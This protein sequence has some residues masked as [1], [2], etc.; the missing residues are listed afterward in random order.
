MNHLDDEHFSG[1]ELAE[2][3]FLSREQTHRKIKQSTSL[4]TGKFIRYIKILKAYAY[5][6]EGNFSVSE[7]S[8]KVGF[9]DPSYFNKCF[10][11]ETGSSPGEVKK[12]GDVALLNKTPLFPFYEIPEIKE[13]LEK[14]GVIF[15]FPHSDKEDHAIPKALSEKQKGKTVKT[16]LIAGTASFVLLISLFFWAG[17]KNGKSK[18]DLKGNNRIVVLPFTNRTGDSSLNSI[19]DIAS[20]WLSNQLAELKIIQT[21]PYFTIKQYQ[22]YIGILPDDPQG[23]PTFQD[24][25]AARYFING[26]YYLKDSQVFFDA[27]FVD[28]GSLQ[29]IYSLPPIHGPLDSVMNMIEDIRLKFAGLI[30]NLEE[31][32]LGKRNPPNYEAYT[33]FL[34]GLHEMTVGLSTNE[35]QLYLEK[36]ATLEPNFVMP[37]VYLGWYYRGKKFDSLLQQIAA[38][39]TITK[40]E[41]DV[42]DFMYHLWN[43][44][45]KESFQLVF[46]DI[47]KYPGDYFFNLFA[48]YNA[49]S[50]FFPRLALK[51]LDQIKDPLP[52]NE[53]GIWHYY[54]VWNYSE[55]LLMLGQYQDA[56]NYLQ[57]IPLEHYNLAIPHLLISALV[58]LGKPGTEV[59][60]LIEKIAKEKMKYLTGKF[61]LN[62]QKIFAEYYTVAAYYFY[63][64]G[65]SETAH[66]FAQKA[67]AVYTLIPN[68]NAIRFDIVDALYLSGDLQKT[69]KHLET[70]L[71]K[72]PANDNLL[73]YLANVEATLGNE[74]A[75]L[76]IF[77]RYD[78]MPRIYWRRHEFPYHKDYLKARIYALLGKK[79][80]AFAHLQTALEE[81]QLCHTWDF[82]GDIFLRPLFNY[83]PFIEMIRPRDQRDSSIKQ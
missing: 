75:A 65:K 28:A 18:I 60:A 78:T 33:A 81:G 3:L 76:S 79:D 12:S 55:S 32:K 27:G 23:R 30:T 34:K 14:I 50:Q 1:N 6:L 35:S 10:K 51:V 11:E 37:R 64:S 7:I 29:T 22:S 43:G 58:K 39:P 77:A 71:K 46:Q 20:S 62:E 13:Q 38:I 21:V 36:A 59:E 80:Q 44:N 16:W 24:L 67:V 57:S 52:N 26:N 56:I 74:N 82:N 70:E 54:K 4:S 8:Y 61:K 9:E 73:I 72:N 19:G 53:G 40:Y 5:L 49:K 68:Q 66:Y 31:V 47:E 41:K 48:G 45:Y 69:K 15:L 42:Y 17:K 2:K 25:V 63:L 83:A